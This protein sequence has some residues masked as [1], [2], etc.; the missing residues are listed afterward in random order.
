MTFPTGVTSINLGSSGSPVQFSVGQYKP[1]APLGERFVNGYITSSGGS[2]ALRWS[3]PC[4]NVTSIQTGANTLGA[5][6]TGTYN[7]A[8]GNLTISGVSGTIDWGVGHR[9]RRGMARRGG[10]PDRKLVTGGSGS[11]W[12]AKGGYYP[13]TIIAIRP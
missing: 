10:L 12:T 1:L 9:R 2:G 8:T 5:T 4:L 11:T 13:N 3:N 7:P 6:F